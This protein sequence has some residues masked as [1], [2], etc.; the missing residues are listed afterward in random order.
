MFQKPN[1]TVPQVK[2]RG[3]QVEGPCQYEGGIPTLIHTKT[4]Y[5]VQTIMSLDHHNI[6]IIRA[7]AVHEH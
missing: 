7:S 4:Y 1:R 3:S 5:H 2:V 6:L